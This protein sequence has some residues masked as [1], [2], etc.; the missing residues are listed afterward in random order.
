MLDD[1]YVVKLV[2]CCRNQVFCRSRDKPTFA[3]ADWSPLAPSSQHR[4]L[5]VQRTG[6]YVA[7]HL[8]YSR[9]LH[10]LGAVKLPFAPPLPP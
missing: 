7:F 10:F 9:L 3:K 6:T 2:Q 4:L 5:L 1:A 8:A